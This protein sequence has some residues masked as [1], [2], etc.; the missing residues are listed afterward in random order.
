MS[1]AILARNHFPLGC[2]NHVAQY[3]SH[4]TCAVIFKKKGFNAHFS[5]ACVVS[6]LPEF[7]SSRS[8]TD[9]GRWWTAGIYSTLIQYRS[10]NMFH[11]IGFPNRSPSPPKRA[12]PPVPASR[13][14][15]GAIDA[16]R[17]NV[18]CPNAPEPGKHAC[19]IHHCRADR[20]CPN[21][22]VPG[23][24]NCIIHDGGGKVQMLYCKQ[25]GMPWS[26]VDVP[27]PNGTIRRTRRPPPLC[28][29]RA[30]DAEW[31]FVTPPQITPRV[32]QSQ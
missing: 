5:R 27:G 14:N 31:R 2:D 25:C 3:S 20:Q 24:E 22:R 9:I 30:A 7:L 15:C 19:G 17:P 32:T 13:P 21:R 1:I 11:R 16:N 23:C 10:A 26:E 6:L 12:S 18:P 4:R 8:K 29:H 28:R